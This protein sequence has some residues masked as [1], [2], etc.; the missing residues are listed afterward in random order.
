MPIKC[1]TLETIEDFLGQKRVAM[2]GVSRDPR[3]FSAMLFEEFCR[4]GYDMIAVN[5][6]AKEV[7]GRRCYARVQEIQPPATAVIL[8]TSPQVTDVVVGDC[9]KAGIQRIWMY[10]A[11]GKG[12]VSAKALAFCESRGI[13]VVPGECPYMFFPDAGAGHRFHG[14][15]RKITGHYP[16]HAVGHDARAEAL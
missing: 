4:R 10:R 16:R 9:A 5:P 1:V 2:V 15:I 12:A 3:S 8:M 6:A 11:A 7:L 14:F 13:Q